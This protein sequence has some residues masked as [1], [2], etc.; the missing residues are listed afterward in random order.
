ML[1]AVRVPIRERCELLYNRVDVAFLLDL[2]QD[3]PSPID[4]S[5]IV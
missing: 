3:P 4:F 2:H 5:S 1:A